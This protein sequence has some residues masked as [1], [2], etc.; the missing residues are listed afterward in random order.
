MAPPKFLLFVVTQIEKDCHTLIEQYISLVKNWRLLSV[1]NYITIAHDQFSY[2]CLYSYS[3][4]VYDITV[5]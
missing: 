2:S 1:Y 5:K 4:H 3:T